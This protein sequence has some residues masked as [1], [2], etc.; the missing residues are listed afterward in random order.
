MIRPAPIDQT[1]EASQ[2]LIPRVNGTCQPAC[3]W[4]DQQI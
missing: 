2:F 1:A 4:P 3:L